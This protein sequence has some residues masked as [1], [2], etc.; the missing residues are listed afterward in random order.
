MHVADFC[1]VI[2]KLCKLRLSAIFLLV[3]CTRGFS[4]LR[5]NSVDSLLAYA[6]RNS[7]SMKI[8]TEQSLLAKWTKVAA[9]ANS[10]NFKSPLSFSATD[11][12]QL[13]VNFIPADAF[14]GTAGTFRQITLGQQYVSNFNLA[15]QI[16]IINPYNL[17]RI[18]SAGLNKEL[19]EVANRINKKALF[20][21]ISGAYY[22]CLM[23]KKQITA[24]E[25]SLVLSD[26]VLIIVTNKFNLGVARKQDVNN[27]EATTLTTKDKLQQLQINIEQQLNIV[28][29]LCDIPPSTIIEIDQNTASENVAPSKSLASLN[30]QY[31][32]LQEKY[33]LSELRAGRLSMLPTLSLVYYQGWQKNSNSSFFDGNAPW[34]QSKYVGLRL[35]IPFPPDVNKLSQNYTFNVNHRIATL[36]QHHVSLQNELN[37]GNLD[38]DVAKT[39]ASYEFATRVSD[40]KKFNYQK[41]IE[42][43]NEGIL[44]TDLLLVAYNDLLSSRLNLAAA[45][46]AFENSKTK[47]FLNNRIK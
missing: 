24:T 25:K 20:E 42:Q 26:S 15:P 39:Q 9:I 21:S 13:P 12:L 32:L 14:G 33:A 28:K 10:I 4:Q 22:N 17:A 1:A 27:A 16:D 31:S 47:V 5:F 36:N 11:N 7:S 8:A 38:L 44:S 35:A 30:S 23:L 41:S 29:I 34:I 46:A 3:F 18:K 2:I 45:Q 37:N 40:L 43:Y 6:E 19:T